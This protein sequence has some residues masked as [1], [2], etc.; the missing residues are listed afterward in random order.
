MQED[1]HIARPLIHIKRHR[2]NELLF[3]AHEPL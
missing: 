1:E 3:R 2:E